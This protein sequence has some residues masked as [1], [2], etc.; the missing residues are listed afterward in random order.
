M[1]LPSNLLA[2][3]SL[4]IGAGSAISE[5]IKKLEASSFNW[6]HI[7]VTFQ[8]HFITYLLMFVSI[9]RA[10][11]LLLKLIHL[12]VREV[13]LEKSWKSKTLRQPSIQLLKLI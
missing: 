1:A 8:S 12:F 3:A 11:L 5:K 13:L 4:T 2:Y 7:C 9:F 6:S 10:E